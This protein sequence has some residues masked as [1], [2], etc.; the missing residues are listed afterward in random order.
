MKISPGIRKFGSYTL[1]LNAN[2]AV[3][4]WCDRCETW[5]VAANA[6]RHFGNERL[7]IALPPK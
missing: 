7:H 1:W 6:T 4:I 2:H 5:V 3:V